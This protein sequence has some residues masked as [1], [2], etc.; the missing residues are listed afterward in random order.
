MYFGKNTIKHPSTQQLACQLTRVECKQA[1]PLRDGHKTLWSL[2]H[3]LTIGRTKAL[4]LQVC[5]SAAQGDYLIRFS[6]K[7]PAGVIQDCDKKKEKK[8][9]SFSHQNRYA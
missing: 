2:L 4:C 9:S 6:K 3:W 1:S 5:P 7:K 8:S